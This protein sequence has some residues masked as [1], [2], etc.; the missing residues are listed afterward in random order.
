M[1]DS[2]FV[3]LASQSPRRRQLLEQL[4]ASLNSGDKDLML[5]QVE[6]LNEYTRPF[7]E[8]VM[9]VAIATAM[10]GKQID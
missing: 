10:K 3:Y 7:A 9:D 8:R 2:K 6:A 5:K 1:P 4:R